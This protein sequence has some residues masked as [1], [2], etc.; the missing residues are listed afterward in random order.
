MATML[1]RQEMIDIIRGGGS[2]LI[3]G[4]G[5]VARVQDLPS[6]A[7]LAAGD[8]AREDAALAALEA[9]LQARQAELEQAREAVRR[10]REGQR[11]DRPPA[12][13]PPVTGPRAV[14]PPR[15]T[16]PGP[17][18]QPPALP[19]E[20][21]PAGCGAGGPDGALAA[22]QL[23]PP[24]RSG[25]V[26][27]QGDETA[28]V[29]QPA[30]P[31]PGPPVRGSLEEGHPPGAHQAGADQAVAPAGPGPQTPP[32]ATSTD[33]V[34]ADQGGADRDD[35]LAGVVAVFAAECLEVRP[36]LELAVTVA[37]DCWAAWCGPRGL[38]PSTPQ[39]FG[40]LLRGAISGLEEIR[41]R[42][43]GGR[44]RR[45][46]GIGRKAEGPARR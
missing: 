21:L 38:S 25:A 13:P 46:V 19:G 24:A 31:P 42:T 22:G 9:Q 43:P 18:L 2:V 6:E 37:F 39:H 40:R 29:S 11:A 17:P 12:P 4:V 20:G 33:R 3:R 41:P 36:G 27:P 5:V 35:N 34:G 14:V 26:A 45:Y 10:R 32:P 16:P 44:E 7:L 8:R 28:A 23:G 1:S 15:Q 30:V